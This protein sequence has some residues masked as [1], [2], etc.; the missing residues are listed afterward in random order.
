MTTDNDFCL[1]TVTEHW[2]CW[3]YWV[4]NDTAATAAAAAAD[5]DDATNTSL[6]EECF[7]VLTGD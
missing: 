3:C 2:Q 1:L 4:L 7:Y 6:T 5:D